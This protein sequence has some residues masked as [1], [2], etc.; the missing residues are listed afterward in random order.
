[1]KKI[2]LL[3]ICYFSFSFVFSE[4]L[5]DKAKVSVITCGYGTQLYAQFGHTAIRV[6]DPGTSPTLDVAF[7]YGTFDYDVEGFYIKFVKGITDYQLSIEFSQDLFIRYR[8][9][10]IAV[11]EQEL[12]LSQQEKQLLFES[13]MSNYLPENRFYRYNYV[14]DNCATKPRDMVE[15]A[16]KGGLIYEEKENKETFR[17]LIEECVGA[18]TWNKFA[19]DIVLGSSSDE[20]ATTRERMFMPV[21]L[22]NYLKT[23]Q[24][25]DESLIVSETIQV[26][27]ATNNTKESSFLLQPLFVSFAFLFLIGI[28]SY[29]GRNNQMLWIDGLLYTVLGLI[30]IVVFYLSFF[31]A[32]PLVAGNYNL[33]WLN[34]VHLLFAL[35]L[36]SKKLRRPLYYYQVANAFAVVFAIAGYLILPQEFNVAFLPIMLLILMRSLFYIRSQRISSEN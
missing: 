3:F 12:N 6:Y 17:Q 31:S 27:Q 20:I 24:R 7:S 35:S 15:N 25:E 23:A 8:N 22:M 34:P 32:H 5:S 11:W 19:I 30:G 13:L 29:L 2:L 4:T 10:G 36:L 33:L 16:V 14:Y 28:I 26:Y 18:S 1:M 21:E 9:K